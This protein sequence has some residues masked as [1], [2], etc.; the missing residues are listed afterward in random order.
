MRLPIIVFT[1]AL[2]LAGFARAATSAADQAAITAYETRLTPVSAKDSSD[3]RT[4]AERMAEL[5]VRG[6]SIAFIE[7][8][9]VKWTRA[10]GETTAGTGQAV[11]PDTLF[12]A[13]S[14][15]KALA[16]A[17]ALR[18]VE[19]RKLDLDSDI[20]SYLKSWQVPA[21]PYTAVQKVTLR[22]LL[23]HTAGLT[24]SGFP[25]YAAD[26]AVPTTVQ[27][28]DGTP[29]ANTPAVRSFEAPG[30]AYAYSGGG[31]TVAQLAIVEAGAKPYPELLGEL[32][33]RPAA[34]RQSTFAQP[35]PST[36]LVR[37]ASG[38]DR[39]GDVIPGGRNTYP[40]YAAAGLW[41]TASDYGRFYIALQNA[42]ARTAHALLRPASAQ[43]MMTPVD[44][45]Y[46]L[47]LQIGRW[48]GHPFIQ[49]SGGNEGFQCNAFAFLDG[50]RQGVVI[51]TN[52]AVGSVVVNEIM[53][54]LADAY[55]WGEQDPATKGSPRRAPNVPT[56]AK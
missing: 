52:S 11:T 49:H 7:D 21:S 55:G 33:L 43:A 19:Q 32:V 41:T 50:S 9:R 10:Y 2:G 1:L 27:I 30:G 6:V 4:L 22:R 15:S 45:N 14:M 36:W 24:V 54:A 18:L 31:Y 34:M 8:G 48:G 38:H 17:A 12:Q 23:S 25:G 40:E 56:G 44:A 13:A 53:H 39:K 35:L 37:A 46:G 42:Q 28:L 16:A 47:G 20:N 5:K 29:P 3:T 51:M 26:R